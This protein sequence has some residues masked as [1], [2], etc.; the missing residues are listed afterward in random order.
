MQ[1]ATALYHFRGLLFSDRR[2][3]P[4]V[5]SS[6]FMGLERRQASDSVGF[7]VGNDAEGMES[8]HR[9]LSDLFEL[10][11]FRS[12]NGLEAL[13]DDVRLLTLLKPELDVE[14][15]LKHL[16]DHHNLRGTRRKTALARF[17]FLPWWRNR[18]GQKKI[19][20]VPRIDINSSGSVN[21][22]R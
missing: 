21:R 18:G 19:L 15:E 7:S 6:L 13:R 20:T 11:W 10:G 17:K 22:T 1:T 12:A 8:N 16:E 3:V 5:S 4:F 14:V 9:P 2:P